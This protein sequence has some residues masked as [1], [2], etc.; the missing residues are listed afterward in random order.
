MFEDESKPLDEVLAYMRIRE[1]WMNPVF[2][3]SVLDPIRP[4]SV[5]I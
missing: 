2:G 1:G 3:G 4:K 5:L